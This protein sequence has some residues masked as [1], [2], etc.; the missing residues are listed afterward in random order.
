[1]S[2]CVAVG[3]HIAVWWKRSGTVSLGISTSSEYPPE[4]SD[5]NKRTL[6]RLAADF[7]LSGSV[8][9]KRNHDMVLL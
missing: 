5:N 3:P 6:R 1:M 2:S 7:F 9:Y 4:A 8:L